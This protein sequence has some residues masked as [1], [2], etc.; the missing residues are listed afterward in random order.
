MS[1][2]DKLRRPAEKLFYSLPAVDLKI[3][4][5]F[6]DLWTFDLLFKIPLHVNWTIVLF[7]VFLCCVYE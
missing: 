6:S 4:N 1:F 5:I 7:I 3:I 2:Q